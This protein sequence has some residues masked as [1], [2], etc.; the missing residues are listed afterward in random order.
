[1]ISSECSILGQCASSRIRSSSVLM[2][3]QECCEH[4][5]D[6]GG[7]PK[8]AYFLVSSPPWVH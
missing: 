6:R 3:V 4:A 8:L 7:C 1:M 5:L 2:G